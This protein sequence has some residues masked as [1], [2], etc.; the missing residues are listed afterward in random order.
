M[1][2][3]FI[4]AD[5]RDPRYVGEL[6]LRYRVL[7]V[8]LGMGRETVRFPFEDDS[9]HLV[10]QD[11]VDDAVIG[12]VLFYPDNDGGGRLFQMAVDD[13]LQRGGVGRALVTRLEAHLADIG[14]ARVHL[15]ARD[16]AIGF[17]Q[18]LGYVMYGEPF[19]EVGVEHR[20]MAKSL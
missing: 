18:R 7:R 4:D 19:G 9:L 8:P 5:E 17:Y 3:T 1:R 15:H 11:D 10:A 2:L 14:V 6:D 16:S 13:T 12:C 20:H